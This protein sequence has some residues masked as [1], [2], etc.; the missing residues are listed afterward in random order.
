M[1][2]LP[3]DLQARLR[4][5]DPSKPDMRVCKVCGQRYDARKLA[6]AYH[7]DERPH[8]PLAKPDE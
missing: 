2:S 1:S 5:R 3:P 6:Q 7:H 8:E 4:V